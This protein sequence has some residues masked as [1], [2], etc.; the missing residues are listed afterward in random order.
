M[1]GGGA[2]RDPLLPHAYLQGGCVSGG[3]RY[4]GMHAIVGLSRLCREESL[5]GTT[6]SK[7]IV[8]SHHYL[9]KGGGSHT[10]PDPPPHPLS[11]GALEALVANGQS[12]QGPPPKWV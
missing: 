12:Q 6:R 4:R 10:G 2:A 3:L 9:S 5:K 11:T 8:P 1:R 7:H